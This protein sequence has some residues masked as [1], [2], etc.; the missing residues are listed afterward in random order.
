M[1]HH[2]T[3]PNN[4]AAF[5]QQQGSISSTTCQHF[6]KNMSAFHQ[7]HGSILPTTWQHH[8]NT[9]Q[10]A[11]SLSDGRSSTCAS[12]VFVSQTWVIM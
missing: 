3:F 11:A 4:M 9:F 2:V 8:T 7:Q 5:H 1:L 6:T 10:S 12:N